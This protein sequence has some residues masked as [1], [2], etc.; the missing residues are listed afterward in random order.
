MKTKTTR[1]SALL[2]H[3]VR[4]ANRHPVTDDLAGLESLLPLAPSEGEQLAIFRAQ[5]P[6]LLDLRGRGQVH[7]E[8]V[9]R[10]I[11]L[12]AKE[13]HL[14]ETWIDTANA[15]TVL[16]NSAHLALMLLPVRTEDDAWTRQQ[17]GQHLLN[18]ARAHGEREDIALAKRV[19]G[20]L[21]KLLHANLGDPEGVEAMIATMVRRAAAL[22][23]A[24]TVDGEAGRPGVH[25]L[26]QA[27][28]L[29]A[30]FAAAPDLGGLLDQARGLLAHLDRAEAYGPGAESDEAAQEGA[31]ILAYARLMRV[32][33]WPARNTADVAA[34][35]AA[36]ALVDGRHDDPDRYRAL[37]AIAWGQGETIAGQSHRFIRVDSKE[38]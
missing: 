28:S 23:P 4:D 16:T 27:D 26:E 31:L 32:A 36:R 11:K 1:Q 18:R 19:V 35:I 10:L 33:L 12:L 38:G 34:K 21:A 29:E 37:F 8:Q 15:L 14:V 7:T 30:F 3:I 24:P 6:A 2:S 22:H 25:T 17:F 20:K 9:Q 5:L 13:P